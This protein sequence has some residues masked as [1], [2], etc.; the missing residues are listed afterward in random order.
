MLTVGSMALASGASTWEA[1]YLG[2]VA[3]GI[4]TYR[5]GNIPISA[6]ELFNALR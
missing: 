2:S 5:V 4:Q 6:S 3:A 1:A